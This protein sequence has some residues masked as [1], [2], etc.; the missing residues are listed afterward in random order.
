M[1]GVF[2]GEW[3]HVCAWLSSFAIHLKLSQHCELAILPKENKKLKK[4]KVLK[5]LF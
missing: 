4:K 3:I 1:G 2:G 5:R